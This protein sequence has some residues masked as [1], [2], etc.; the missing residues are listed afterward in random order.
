MFRINR[1]LVQLNSFLIVSSITYHLWCEVKSAMLLFSA[2]F[3]RTYIKI[4]E[5]MFKQDHN[6]QIKKYVNFVNKKSSHNY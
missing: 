4:H 2:M 6:L 3:D 1:Y 5:A